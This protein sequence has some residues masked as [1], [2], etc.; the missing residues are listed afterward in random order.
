MSA[1]LT[2]YDLQA[3]EQLQLASP[4]ERLAKS[5]K[6][7]RSK[8]S[9]KPELAFY[10][11]YTEAMLR[12][13][14]RLSMTVGRMPALLGHDA[15]RGKMSTYRVTSFE[16]SVIFVYDVEKCLKRLDD[17]SQELIRR[18]ALQEYTQGEAAGLLRVSL[19]TIVRRYGEAIDSLTQIFVNY[20]LLEIDPMDESNTNQRRSV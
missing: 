10:R 6:Q 11:K 16:D 1:A 13:Y 15:F 8:A 20:R 7:V 5:L 4:K 9:P 3:A 14:M 2:L 19:R 18:I 12:R 17:F